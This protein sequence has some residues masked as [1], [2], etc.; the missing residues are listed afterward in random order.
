MLRERFINYIRYE[1]RF[2]EHI[3]KAYQTDLN[4]FYSWLDTHYD[5]N[6]PSS[7]G[8]MII[9]S[10]LV[11]LMDKGISPRAVNRKLSSLRS[12]YKFLIREGMIDEN[13]MKKIIPPKAGKKLPVFV[14][15]EKMALLLDNVSFGD[16]FA[17]IRDR[18]IIELLYFT[19]IR[20][21]ELINIRIS[22][23]H[24]HDLVIK[25][26]GKRNKER[27]IPI[28]SYLSK[29]IKEYIGLRDREFG[30]SNKSDFL[31]V[32]NKGAKTYSKLIYRVVNRYLGTVTTHDKRSPHVLRHSFATHMLNNGADLN[33]IKEILGHANLSATQVYTHNT[34]DKLKRIYKQAHPRA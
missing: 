23:I 11:H 12:F 34:I 14:E 2:S 27:L 9:R 7:I 28:N 32:T 29:S 15:E 24:F 19:G 4:Q 25:V 31:I 30:E 26:V 1:K 10:W 21:S 33:A 20:L 16:G 3:I 8:Y 17:D 22:D 6:D 5:I 13:P 18:L